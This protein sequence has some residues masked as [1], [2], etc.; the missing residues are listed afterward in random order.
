MWVA[1][2]NFSRF[3]EGC[4][5]RIIGFRGADGFELSNLEAQH[6]SPSLK[7]ESP[8][9]CSVQKLRRVE[10]NFTSRERAGRLEYIGGRKGALDPTGQLAVTVMGNW[11]RERMHWLSACSRIFRPVPPKLHL[12]LSGSAGHGVVNGGQ[13][14]ILLVRLGLQDRN[15]VLKVSCTGLACSHLGP[16][17]R[18]IDG[19]FNMSG[20]DAGVDL[21][22]LALDNLLIK[23]QRVQLLV[24]DGIFQCSPAT[25]EVVNRRMQ[26]VSRELWVQKFNTSPP[27]RMEPFGGVGVVLIGD[28]HQ[29]SPISNTDL[30]NRHLVLAGLQ[31]LTGFR[32]VHGCE[33]PWSQFG[34]LVSEVDDSEVK[35]RDGAQSFKRAFPYSSLVNKCRRV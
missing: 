28:P 11:A 23:L 17:W 9:V 34:D 3:E 19:V 35:A 5:N 32:D 6:G 27:D 30:S 16:S 7:R 22:G 25:L 26:Q 15:C 33:G 1:K 2:L 8:C 21:S 24:I 18:P 20:V 31:T 14:G 4:T 10:E 13:A 12:F 29:R